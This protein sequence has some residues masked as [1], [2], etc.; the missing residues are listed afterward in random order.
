MTGIK[1]IASFIP[2]N[3]LDNLEQGR[4]FGES[5]EFIREKIGATRLARMTD[6]METS[7]MAVGAINALFSQTGLKL[8]QVEA[9]VVVTQNPDG[10]GLPHTSAIVQS[11]AGLPTNIAAF[12]VSLGCSGYVYGLA[13]IKGLMATTGMKNG[14]L[15]TADP[16]S[17]VID[18][19]DRVTTLLFGDAATA[20]W[21]GQDPLYDVVTP[22][23]STDGSGAEH[24][25]VEEGVLSMNGR[26]VFNFA[27]TKV[28][29]Q[30]KEY[31]QQHQL[32]PQDIDLYCMHQGSASIVS[33]IA[34]RF[35]EVA[36]RFVNDMDQTGN[37][38]SSTLPLLLEKRIHDP[39]NGTILLSGF[40]VGLSWATTLLKRNETC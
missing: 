10:H 11:K 17:K 27:A 15:V 35:N 20:T 3:T 31:L 34:R 5:E 33:T 28:P 26:Q 9:L 30:I 18:P 12:D 2:D 1:A 39:A 7:D 16:Y 24:L 36:D 13:I 4:S 8:E 40:G 14:I 6:G 32:Q 38:V 19:K 21:I 37:A 29:Q 23:F 22:V 25:K